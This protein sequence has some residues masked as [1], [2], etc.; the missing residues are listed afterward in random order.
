MGKRHLQT[1]EISRSG[2]EFREKKKKNN[3][4]IIE[5]NH[6]Q[7]CQDDKRRGKKLVRERRKSRGAQGGRVGAGAC[8]EPF[9]HGWEI[10]SRLQLPGCLIVLDVFSVPQER[11]PDLAAPDV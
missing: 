6:S 9:S 3:S 11:H 1:M 2:K 8:S 4:K 10:P 7:H 5:P